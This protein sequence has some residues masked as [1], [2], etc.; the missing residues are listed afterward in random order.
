MTG[1][2]PSTLQALRCNYKRACILAAHRSARCPLRARDWFPPQENAP[3]ARA[4]ERNRGQRLPARGPPRTL[5]PSTRDGTRTAPAEQPPLHLLCEGEAAHTCRGRCTAA[6][7]HSCGPAHTH[8]RT[9]YQ[10]LDRIL[11][12]PSTGSGLSR[13]RLYRGRIA[14]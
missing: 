14:P 10:L 9:H 2:A 5:S 6:A 7:P 8:I 13:Y 3:F 1:L 12:I 4:I 11:R